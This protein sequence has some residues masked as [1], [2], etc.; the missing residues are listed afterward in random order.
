[1]K[2]KPVISPL[3]FNPKDQSSLPFTDI[4]KT[5]ILQDQF[6]SVFMKEPFG[7]LPD[8]QSRTDVKV[9]FNLTIDMVKSERK[10]LNPNKLIGPDEIHPTMLKKLS[11]H[12][13]TPLH[14]IY[15]D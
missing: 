8:F 13:A 6:C 14:T 12:I 11:D 5:D 10:S 3:L 4:D 9:E 2:T 1:M 7:S 15:K